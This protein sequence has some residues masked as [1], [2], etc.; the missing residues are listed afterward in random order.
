MGWGSAFAEA[1][2]LVPSVSIH[3][4]G[5]TGPTFGRGSSNVIKKGQPFGVRLVNRGCRPPGKAVA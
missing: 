4:V 2:E 1:D 5:A 3:A